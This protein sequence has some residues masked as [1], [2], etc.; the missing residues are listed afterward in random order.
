[1]HD[2]LNPGRH[3]VNFHG[4]PSQRISVA[5][6]L[7]DTLFAVI[8]LAIVVSQAFIL[9]S[10]A[11]GMRHG[12]PTARPALEWT[13]AIVPAIALAA[14]LFFSWRAMHPEVINVQG[15]APQIGMGW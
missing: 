3:R 15:V 2:V 14:L 7:A 12:G 11:R 10:T 13:Y 1:M 5:T 4:S 8:A 9:R 6:Q